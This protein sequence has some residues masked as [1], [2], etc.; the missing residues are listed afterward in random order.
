MAAISHSPPYPHRRQLKIPPTPAFVH[1]QATQLSHSGN[2]GNHSD[3][4]T[5]VPKTNPSQQD[6]TKR[7]LIHGGQMKAGRQTRPRSG[8]AARE[9]R[10]VRDWRGRRGETRSTLLKT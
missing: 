1:H 8:A 9:E 4:S 6:D 5:Y 10:R 3:T 2:C 7:A